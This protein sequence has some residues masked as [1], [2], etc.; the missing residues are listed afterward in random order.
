MAIARWLV[1]CAQISEKGPNLQAPRCENGGLTSACCGQLPCKHRS[2]LSLD[3]DSRMVNFMVSPIAD[4]H[5]PWPYFLSN[6]I[7]P[8]AYTSPFESLS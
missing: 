6:D 1:L 5:S 7:N 2:K 3:Q 4:G 8:L